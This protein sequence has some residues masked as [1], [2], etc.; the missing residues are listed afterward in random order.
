MRVFLD[1]CRIAPA[2]FDVTVKTAKEAIDLLK[3]GKVT[4]ISLDHD[5]GDEKETGSGYE[6]ACFIE[7]KAFDGSLCELT[8]AIHSA[9]PVGR[10]N[11][12]RA[13]NNA[14]RYW[15]LT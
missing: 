1:D 12:T 5:L 7:E 6:V 13:L 14:V 8:W 9:N 3:T 4:H 2:D 10:E 15:G 11:M